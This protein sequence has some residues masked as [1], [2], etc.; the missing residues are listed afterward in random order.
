MVESELDTK[1]GDDDGG[2]GREENMRGDHCGTE[3]VGPGEDGGALH[4]SLPHSPHIAPLQ[5]GDE[6]Q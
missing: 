1:F 6:L 5:A 3:D 2:R 4:Q